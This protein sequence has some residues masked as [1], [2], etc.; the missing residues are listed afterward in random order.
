[1]FTINLTQE[2]E[3]NKKV[4]KKLRK[5]S[6]DMLQRHFDSLNKVFSKK[7]ADHKARKIVFNPNKNYFRKLKKAYKFG[8]LEI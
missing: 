8:L 6:N 2:G 3:M 5:Y 4:V 1:M 7:I